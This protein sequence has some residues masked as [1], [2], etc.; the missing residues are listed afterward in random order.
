LSCSFILFSPYPSTG[1]KQT[2]ENLEI[3]KKESEMWIGSDCKDQVRTDVIDDVGELSE[4]DLLGYGQPMLEEPE[5]TFEAEELPERQIEDSETSDA[6]EIIYGSPEAVRYFQKVA[7]P[8]DGTESTTINVEDLSARSKL[9]VRPLSLPDT[10]V[11]RHG[12]PGTKIRRTDFVVALTPEP[13]PEIQPESI[14][15]SVEE[16]DTESEPALETELTSDLE[17]GLEIDQSVPSL[18]EEPYSIEE[19]VAVAEEKCDSLVE[20]V[21]EL[22]LEPETSKLEQDEAIEQESG[23]EVEQAMEQI[24]GST[25]EQILESAIEQVLEPEVSSELD[26]TIKAEP[27]FELVSESVSESENIPVLE[28]SLRPVSELEIDAELADQQHETALVEVIAQDEKGS[29][30][31]SLTQA[32]PTEIVPEVEYKETIPVPDESL[33]PALEIKQ[34]SDM[35]SVLETKYVPVVEIES[36]SDAKL[37]EL[38]EDSEDLLE[39]TSPPETDSESGFSPEEDPESIPDSN[40]IENLVAVQEENSVSVLEMEPESD[41]D[42]VLEKVTELEI[43]S[44]C[45]LEKLEV[46][47]TS[48]SVLEEESSLKFEAVPEVELVSQ[49]AS[50]VETEPEQE[51]ELVFETELVLETEPVLQAKL[52]ENPESDR[53]PPDGDVTE[54]VDELYT[55]EEDFENKSHAARVASVLND[56]HRLTPGE[57]PLDERAERMAEAILA[58]ALFETVFLQPEEREE[59][60]RSFD[61]TPISEP[62]FPSTDLPFVGSSFCRIQ[63]PT[64]GTSAELE[65][66]VSFF[67]FF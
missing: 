56:V 22:I 30:S 32:E 54:E 39:L 18:E 21:V 41:L 63:F 31:V 2:N 26:A 48:E 38:K 62:S 40:S 33:E 50:I 46:A 19:I 15:A 5:M 9:V 55:E 28:E 44:D 7:L 3:G 17:L 42:P 67:F 1:K 43:G 14:P 45:T 53:T 65:I 8:P 66:P 16:L 57:S 37:S 64:T 58:S 6:T 24:M 25:I 23:P 52:Q 4:A 27:E 34:E 59:E 36:I 20:Q 35:I 13:E 51:N 10:Y 12:S 61:S 29:D 11:D 49:T 60:D 47:I